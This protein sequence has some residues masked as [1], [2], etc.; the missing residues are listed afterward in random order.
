MGLEAAIVALDSQ[1][2]SDLIRVFEN[3][4]EPGGILAEHDKAL[5]RIYFH[6]KDGFSFSP[7]VEDEYQC[8][9]DP[10]W[11]AQ[12]QSFASVLIQPFI[13]RPDGAAVASRASALAP[14]HSGHNDCKIVAECELYGAVARLVGIESG[15][16]AGVFNLESPG[17]GEPGGRPRHEN[18]YHEA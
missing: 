13:P 15:V 14:H 5:V 11:L 10:R 7:T 16:V 18:R 1:C 17:F 6:C 9:R 4:K 8:I 3:V 12:H 2:F